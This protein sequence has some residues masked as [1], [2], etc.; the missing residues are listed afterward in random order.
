MKW[1]GSVGYCVPT[2]VPANSGIWQ[3]TI[4]DRYY[5]GDAI[6]VSRRLQNSDTQNDNVTIS[7]QI[8]IVADPYA[9]ENM[10]YIR[11]ATYMGHKWKV[12]SIDVT[13]PRL[14]LT[15]GGMY[16]EH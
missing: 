6:R 8:S 10:N 15:L 2:E 5:Y 14:T 4:V 12:E 13:Y 3:E 1:Y 11:Y 9:H 7:N 16:N